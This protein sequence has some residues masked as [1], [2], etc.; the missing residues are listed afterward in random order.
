[1]KTLIILIAILTITYADDPVIIE[2][3]TDLF[4][5]E[6]DT[7]E[8]SKEELNINSKSNRKRI[9]IQAGA[10]ID[11]IWLKYVNPMKEWKL[12]PWFG[13]SIS[14]VSVFNIA[15]PFSIETGVRINRKGQRIIAE[16]DPENTV[17]SL[18]IIDS[19]SF[20]SS[21]MVLGTAQL[22]IY[23][24]AIPVKF[25]INF[26]DSPISILSGFD[27][28]YILYADEWIDNVDENFK[29]SKDEVTKALNRL[30]ANWIFGAKY[31][32][33]HIAIRIEGYWGLANLAKKDEW[34]SD[35]KSR[36]ISFSMHYV[37]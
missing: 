27:L 19:A 15:E 10:S 30:N 14:G 25:L 37:F 23:N 12:P 13:F 3:D 5:N 32:K 6:I 35:F 33:N 34:Y 8:S 24:A 31:Q 28:G 18:P 36:E 9:E 29:D 1:M 20:D 26:K 21:K 11:A 7:V 22:N 4:V 16:I 2:E 17:I